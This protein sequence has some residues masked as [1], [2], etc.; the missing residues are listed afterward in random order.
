MAKQIKMDFA[1]ERYQ[2][3]KNKQTIEVLSITG[4]PDLSLKFI[5]TFIMTRRHRLSLIQVDDTLF[6]SWNDFSVPS[7]AEKQIEFNWPTCV[8]VVTIYF[9]AFCGVSM[10]PRLM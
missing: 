2:R 9:Y 3:G 1:T 4:A 10:K 7:G 5:K 6:I 8:S